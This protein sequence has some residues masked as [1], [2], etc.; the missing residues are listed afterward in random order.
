MNMNKGTSLFWSGRSKSSSFSFDA[1]MKAP[2][3]RL[4]GTTNVSTL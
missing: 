4:T 3:M 1:T 2:P